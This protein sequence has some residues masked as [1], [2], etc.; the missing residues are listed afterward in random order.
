MMKIYIQSIK[1]TNKHKINHTI[2]YT[3]INI[4]NINISHVYHIGN[5]YFILHVYV[6]PMIQQ[7]LNHF[8]LTFRRGLN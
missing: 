7:K 5:T 4:H 6:S 1:Q 8:L 3:Y 2:G